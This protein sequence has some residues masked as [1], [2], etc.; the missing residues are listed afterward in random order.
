MIWHYLN[1]GYRKSYYW[2]R[3]WLFVRDAYRELRCFMQRG[4]N[5]WC[6]A[7]TWD[8]QYYLAQVMRDSIL[9]LKKKHHG[10]PGYMTEKKW[11]KELLTMARRFDMFLELDDIRLGEDSVEEYMKKWKKTHKE[12]SKVWEQMNKH[13]MH[14]WD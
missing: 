3:P 14:L 10:Y 13:F 11:D 1:Q 4:A 12:A 2:L 8:L 7:D 6:N 9:H 5:G